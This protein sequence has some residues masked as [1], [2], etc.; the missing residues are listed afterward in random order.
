MNCDNQH[1][2]PQ[3]S[4]TVNLNYLSTLKTY[5]QELSQ[6]PLPLFASTKPDAADLDGIEKSRQKLEAFST[7]SHFRHGWLKSWRAGARAI[8]WLGH[9]SGADNGLNF[10]F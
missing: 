9:A 7:Y 6:N 3:E 2:L 10:I 4:E 5:C 8:K 1:A